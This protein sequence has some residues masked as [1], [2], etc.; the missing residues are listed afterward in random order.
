[1]GNAEVAENEKYFVSW[2]P[3]ITN[4]IDS[5]LLKEEQ[6][7]IYKRYQKETFSRRFVVKAA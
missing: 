7:E 5:K 6:P 4:Q 2:K 3:V 1:M